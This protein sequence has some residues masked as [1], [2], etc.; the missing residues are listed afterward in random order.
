MQVSSGCRTLLLAIL[1]SLSGASALVYQ[2]AWQRILA[3]QSGVGIHSIATI[4]AAFMIGLGLGSHAG[5]AWS[6]RCEPPRALALF[7]TME[8]ALAMFA[9]ASAPLYYDLLYLR[10]TWLREPGWTCA[11]GHCLLLLPPTFLMGASLP[12]LV[13][14][15]IRGEG[16]G[17]TIGM[18][19]GLNVLGAAAGALL[20]P[21]I[22]IR[23]LGVRGALLAGATGNLA[24]GIGALLLS[25]MSRAPEDAGIEAAPPP[26]AAGPAPFPLPSACLLY[27]A[28][29]F[30]ALALEI[31]WFRIMDA[32]VKSTAFTFGT[33]LAIY[34]LGLGAGSLL[35][36]RGR[37]GRDPASRFLACQC[38]L[39]AWAGAAV[40]LL[41][42]LPTGLPAY[43]ALFKFW[44]PAIRVPLLPEHWPTFWKGYAGL[45]GILP[46]ALFGIPTVLM[47]VSFS[48]LQHAVQADARRCGLRVGL[49]QGSNILGCALGSLVCGLV[50]VPTWGTA[51]AIR[52][53]VL[54]GGLLFAGA[55]L[56][57][58]GQ[59]RRFLTLACALL[60]GL[61]LLPG[62]DALW[63][64][65]HG[66]TDLRAFIVEDATSVSAIVPDGD[67]WRILVNNHAHS[68]FPYGGTHTLLGIIPALAHPDPRTAAV[69]GLGS[70]ET[71]WAI[72]CR[73][74]MEHVSLY[75][76]SRAQATV[77]RLFHAKHGYPH[78]GA[79]L[80]DPRI[81]IVTADG[82]NALLRETFER[83]DLLEADAIWPWYAYS[84]NLYSREFF[85]LCS[86]RLREG[87]IMCQWG[88]SDRVRDTFRSVFPHVLEFGG[89]GFLI[90]SREP[91]RADTSAWRARLRE[92]AVRAYLGEP[93][94]DS[95]DAY[96]RGHPPVPFHGSPGTLLNTDLFPRDEFR[97]PE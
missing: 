46:L 67:G 56:L 28:S 23:F 24:A 25:A 84:W 6:A 2:V 45:Y 94:A 59:R 1:F 19:Y 62:N 93:L 73:P 8:L 79:L 91:I 15:C 10:T 88:A 50:L 74:S 49:L 26:T 71:A 53:I 97:T 12:I 22:L 30:C 5:G 41:V 87:G 39:L 7:A 57:R 72:A 40:G 4:V 68:W 47:G 65:L 37:G 3:L 13:R 14:A 76:L 51:G 17:R 42:R 32:A 77:L 81:R 86:A 33:V 35:G 82:R 63:R 66:Q 31:V 44:Y 48:A 11:A 60:G 85:E 16:A 75:E 96:L 27:F 64:R 18:L 58:G 83:Y 29:G 95:V 78:L 38:L 55:G 36:A 70:G 54:G 89:G 80:R 69:V 92:P 43:R 20:T 90:G 52:A 34:L 61:F 21:W 9:V